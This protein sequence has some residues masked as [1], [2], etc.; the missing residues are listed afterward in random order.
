MPYFTNLQAKC[1]NQDVANAFFTY[2]LD[3]DAVSL[4]VIPQTSIR[5][6]LQDQSLPSPLKFLNFFIEEEVYEEGM[7]VAG[8]EIYSKYTKWCCHN[9]EK[10]V[11]NTKFG[12]IIKD[13]WLKVKSDVI[14]KYTISY[15]S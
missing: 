12:T 7:R 5:K 15:K 14:M 2:V 13:K 3:F 8:S 11:S 1:F 4:G 9:G 10:A 6:Q